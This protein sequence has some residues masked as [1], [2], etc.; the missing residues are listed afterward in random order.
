MKTDAQQIG[1]K[2]EHIYSN[3]NNDG[4]GGGDHQ[5][6]GGNTE[7]KVVNNVAAAGSGVQQPSWRSSQQKANADLVLRGE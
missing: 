1:I 5:A 4:G 2:I 3:N 6:A 7:E